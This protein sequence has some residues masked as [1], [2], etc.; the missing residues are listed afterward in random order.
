MRSTR[1]FHFVTGRNISTMS[2]N[3]CD[4][5]CS[6]SE[7][8]W[9]VSDDHRRAVQ[10]RVRDAGDEVGGAGPEGRHRNRAAPRQAAVDVGHERGA[11]LMARGDVADALRVGE[12]VEDVHRLLARDGEDV[13]AALG[14]EALDEEPR[15][16]EWTRVG[17]PAR[18]GFGSL[19]STRFFGMREY[20]ASEP[21]WLPPGCGSRTHRG[22]ASLGIG[23]ESAALESPGYFLVGGTG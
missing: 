12:R 5:L 13:F 10:E 9:P 23:T 19:T 7:P 22:G 6:L 4:S 11:L 15:G 3:W 8:T 20:A 16:S 17:L 14:L 21:T 18:A 2:T 1:W